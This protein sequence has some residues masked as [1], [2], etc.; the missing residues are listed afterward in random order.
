M[1]LRW[2]SQRCFVVL[3]FACSQGKPGIS[4]LQLGSLYWEL[5]G[6]IQKCILLYCSGD[7][8]VLHSSVLYCM[9]NLQ[10]LYFDV[11]NYS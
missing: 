8:Q 10:V 9:V 4:A 6:T 11:L 5:T 7:L 2:H 1:Y 3:S